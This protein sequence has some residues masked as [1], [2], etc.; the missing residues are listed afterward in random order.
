M[1][2]MMT[3]RKVRILSCLF[4]TLRNIFKIREKRAQIAVELRNSQSFRFLPFLSKKIFSKR[5]ESFRNIKFTIKE[6][7]RNEI[8]TALS[9]KGSNF[10]FDKLISNYH[11]VE[12][13][14]GE[15]EEII[16]YK[17]WEA[18]PDNH[19]AAPDE[20]VKAKLVSDAVYSPK[21]YKE[22]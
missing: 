1:T 12:I 2:V 8:N 18:N 3:E 7:Q 20:S 5:N 4:K 15:K 22:N 13:V 11:D 9:V 6:S 10:T 19:I 17:I 14:E 16:D 21:C